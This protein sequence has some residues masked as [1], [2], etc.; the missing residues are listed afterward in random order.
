MFDLNQLTQMA[1]QE[2]ASTPSATV[3]AQGSTLQELKARE[4]VTTTITGVALFSKSITS[5]A[6]NTWY[7]Y[8]IKD[9]VN[10]GKW[11]SMM[12]AT[13]LGAQPVQFTS[14]PFR[15]GYRTNA[16]GVKVETLFL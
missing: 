4:G 16:E 1:I 8:S 5:K 7:L 9:A 6:G 14:K 13:D 3:V 11:H 12:S 15:V 2:M 10:L